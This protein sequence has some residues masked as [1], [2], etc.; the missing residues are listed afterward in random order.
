MN[1]NSNDKS[2]Q[3]RGGGPQTPAGKRKA[4][5][6]ALRH[7]LAVAVGMDPVMG[8]S[9]ARI[10]AVL[11]DRYPR[12]PDLIHSIAD[13]QAGILRARAAGVTLINRAMA[14]LPDG[15]D[16]EAEAIAQALPDL[17]RVHR[18]ELRAMGRRSR[19]LRLL[20]R[21]ARLGY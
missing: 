8:T 4:A 11:A 14:S 1:E 13:A 5:G 2:T 18:Y 16:R 15:A 3:R 10:A 21:D 19:A 12:R 20:R 17:V 7:G 9:A 6:N